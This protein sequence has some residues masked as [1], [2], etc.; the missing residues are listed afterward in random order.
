MRTTAR[1][2][3]DRQRQLK[4]VFSRAA[5]VRVW[6]DL[7][8]SQLR[9]QHILDLHDYYDFNVNIEARA[10][11]I[12]ERVLGGQ[13]RA[14]VPVVYKLEKRLGICRHMLVPS[15]SDALVFQVL[16]DHLY[17]ELMAAQ[18]SAQAY[19]AR[20]RHAL[21]LPHEF[22]AEQAY[23]WHILWP[24]FQ[25][26]IWNFSKKCKYLVCTDLANYYDN[27]GFEELRRV[28]SSHVNSSEVLLDLLFLLVQDLAWTPDYL[29]RTPRGLPVIEIE[30]PRL[31]A[32][33][34]L[35][36]IDSILQSRVAGNFVRWMD[37]INFGVGSIDEAHTTLG[38]LSDVLKSR[39][40]AINLSK[41]EVM[42]S[43]E[44][45]HHFMVRENGALATI[46][47]KAIGLKTVTAKD[48]LAKK[49][50]IKLRNHIHNCDARNKDKVTKRYFTI[51]GKLQSDRGVEL[52]TKM[53]L[54][55]AGLR[56][57]V[58]RY[59]SLLPPSAK[60]RSALLVLLDGAPAYDDVTKLSVI[61]A[62]VEHSV[63]LNHFGK[64]FVKQVRAYVSSPATSF[65]WY[66]ALL[67]YAKY[68]TDSDILNLAEKSRTA[69]RADSFLSRQVITA[70][71]RSAGLN[72]SAVERYWGQEVSRGA[73]DAA[74]VA[75]NMLDIA[76]KSFPAK[77]HRTYCYLFPNPGSRVYPIGKF[78]ILCNIAA[79]EMRK[80][81]NKARPEVDAVVEDPWMR[82]AINKIN[83]LWCA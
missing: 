10:D 19:Y 2:E 24:R 64:K 37:D 48:R 79:S 83:P 68:G 35:F 29:P 43:K 34:F 15:P 60:V 14:E 67:F 38:E 74:S 47:R 22:A 32:H 70:L 12:I 65:D 73:S 42:S 39:G 18:P 75:V 56:S 58:L 55:R 1:F 61:R 59:L 69:A 41:T 44:V 8:K 5:L 80:V 7:V 63:P 4:K 57:T 20:D 23:P 52:A 46:Q 50:L 6:R 3:I 71:A 36:E 81:G 21:K 72:W 82:S 45:M 31:L 11:A 33:C 40:L 26:E 28:I 27:I 54:C 66:G 78:L 25:K 13:Y 17:A 49:V 16:T 30:A 62:I 53:Y 77:S 51:L 76:A 9:K